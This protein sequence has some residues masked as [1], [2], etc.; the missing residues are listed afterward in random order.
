MRSVASKLHRHGPGVLG[1][2]VLVSLVIVA[3]AAPWIAPHDP[4]VGNLRKRLLPPLSEGHLLGTDPLGRDVLSRLIYGTR[5]SLSVGLLSVFLAG[6]VGTLIGMT[7]GYYGGWL[8]RILMRIIDVQ[9]S[10][11]FILLALTIAG[12]LGPSFRNILITLVLTTWILYARLARGEVLRL[13][14]QEYV[15]AALALG[16]GTA[17]IF[18]VYL[19]PNVLSSVVVFGSLE[20]GRMI[21]AEASISFLG[22]GIRPP[23]PAWGL[24]LNQGQEYLTTAWWL[25][26]FPGM[27]IALT[28]LAANMMGDW[29]RD[30]QDPKTR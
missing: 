18:R 30:L 1:L 5:V 22:F 12:I 10:F 4:A 25:V 23:T 19:L 28:T 6:S 24:M 11:P 21:I 7:A 15:Q 26:T 27:M 13:R 16:A 20:L 2:V 8:D 9:L 3:I 14:D 29:L 17:R